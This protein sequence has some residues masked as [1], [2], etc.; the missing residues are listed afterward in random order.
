MAFAINVLL[1]TWSKPGEALTEWLIRR[2]RRDNQN[3][4]VEL[5]E[6]D[7]RE[8]IFEFQEKCAKAIPKWRWAAG[9]M[10]LAILV[11]Q[12]LLANSTP[13]TGWA[14][15]LVAMAVSPLVGIAFL[16]GVP[17]WNCA[18]KNSKDLKPPLRTLGQMDVMEIGERVHGGKAS[19]GDHA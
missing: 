1:F 4:R 8:R 10:A 5:E 15:V 13:V 11:A 19:E 2:A 16:L 18:R 7:V 3:S 9:L 12:F 14:M 6:T 17:A